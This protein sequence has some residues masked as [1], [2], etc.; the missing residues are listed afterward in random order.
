M[1]A[2]PSTPPENGAGPLFAYAAVCIVWGSTFLALRVGVE[3]I[4]PWTL[5]AARCLFA[6]S[7]MTGFAL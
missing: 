1:P 7:L 2:A 6:G 4:P 3:T 5:I